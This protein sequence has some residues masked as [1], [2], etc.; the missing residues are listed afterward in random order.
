MQSKPYST[1]LPATPDNLPRS[2]SKLPATTSIGENGGPI[3]AVAQKDRMLLLNVIADRWS[4]GDATSAKFMANMISR[5]ANELAG[6]N[7]SPL[8][9]TIALTAATLWYDT[10]LR[11]AGVGGGSEAHQKAF[12]R[13]LKRYEKIMRLLATVQRVPTYLQVN[14]ASGHQQVVNSPS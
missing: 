4:E 14:I 10:S 5:K 2:F 13:S 9:S 11:M 3:S 12:D 7:P 8:V 6:P 1:N